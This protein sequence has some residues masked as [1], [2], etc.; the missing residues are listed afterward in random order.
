MYIKLERNPISHTSLF[1]NSKSKQTIWHYTIHYEKDDTGK[2]ARVD[3][4]THM[5]ISV[6][7]ALL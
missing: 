6:L 4:G 7:Q 1:A 3:T 2:F 5:I